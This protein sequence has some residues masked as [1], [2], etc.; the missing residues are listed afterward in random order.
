MCTAYSVPHSTGSTRHAGTS[1]TEAN[2]KPDCQKRNN[3]PRHVTN[4]V[5]GTHLQTVTVTHLDN[6]PK[7]TSSTRVSESRLSAAGFMRPPPPLPHAR[8]GGPKMLPYIAAATT[9]T[10]A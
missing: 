2:P 10:P 8:C 9:R 1:N 3:Q 5:G 4:R 6:T 7:P